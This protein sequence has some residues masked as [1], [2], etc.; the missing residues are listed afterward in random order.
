MA[1]TLYMAFRKDT[2]YAIYFNFYFPYKTDKRGL[3]LSTSFS[4]FVN[5]TKGRNIPLVYLLHYKPAVNF[6]LTLFHFVSIRSL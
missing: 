3:L 1:T 2:K 5:K 4:H 6:S